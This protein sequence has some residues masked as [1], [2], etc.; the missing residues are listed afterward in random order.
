MCHVLGYSVTVLLTL[1]QT[2]V[3]S[4]IVIVSLENTADST[5]LLVLFECLQI[6]WWGR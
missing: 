4:V 1:L 6:V 5:L 2:A 3:H